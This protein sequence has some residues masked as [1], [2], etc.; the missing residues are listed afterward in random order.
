MNNDRLIEKLQINH[1]I[2]CESIGLVFK[3]IHHIIKLKNEEFTILYPDIIKQVLRWSKLLD[4]HQPA[5]TVLQ[6]IV[7]NVRTHSHC[8][9]QNFEI[10]IHTILEE[11][12]N[13]S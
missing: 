13:V 2:S 8:M 5:L 3:L 11:C 1:D 4:L 10:I 7:I 12:L 9:D 6:T